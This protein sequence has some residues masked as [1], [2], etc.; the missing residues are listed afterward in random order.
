MKIGMTLLLS[1]GGLDFALANI[2]WHS[3]IVDQIACIAHRPCKLLQHV[4]R[5]AED[6]VPNFTYIGAD[7]TEFPTGEFRNQ[8][9]CNMFHNMIN[10]LKPYNFDWVINADDD[11]F[12][13]GPVRE[14]LEFGLATGI[15]IIYTD[16]HCFYETY[17]D[18]SDRNP[19]RRMLY[20][21]PDNVDYQYKKAIPQL[22]NFQATTPGNHFVQLNK[23]SPVVI[24]FPDL[25]IYH[26]TF[27]KGKTRTPLEAWPI[28][29]ETQVAEKGLVFDPTLKEL[30]DKN[31]IDV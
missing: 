19:V 21:D 22:K 20:R 31:N 8:Y 27:R 3:K 1:D 29:T 28:L 25:Y 9:Q 14:K 23:P 17:H 30:F 11:E 2:L 4:L 26:Y 15:D 16:G 10:Y 6:I 13:V 24:S 18:D 12:Y 5:H 7:F